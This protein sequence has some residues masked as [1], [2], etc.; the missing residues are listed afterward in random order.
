VR[1]LIDDYASLAARAGHSEEGWLEGMCASVRMLEKRLGAAACASL[2]ADLRRGDHAAVARALLAY[3]DALYDVHAVNGLGTGSGGGTRASKVVDAP[4]HEDLEEI[5]A[6]L[7]A[8]AVLRC[9][10]EFDAE[11]RRGGHATGEECVDCV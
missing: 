9:C 6:D 7:L 1:L 8:R 11:A 4:Q 3:Y 10:A 2:C 5:D